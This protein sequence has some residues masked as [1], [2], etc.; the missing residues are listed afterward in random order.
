MGNEELSQEALKSDGSPF[1]QGLSN[2]FG[3]HTWGIAS[4]NKG[5]TREENVHRQAQGGA[6]DNSDHEKQ[7]AP[8][9]DQVDNKKNHKQTLCTLGFCESPSMKTLWHFLDHP[10][11]MSCHK[12]LDEKRFTK[13]NLLLPLI[14]HLKIYIYIG[15]I[16]YA[17]KLNQIPN[18]KAKTYRLFFVL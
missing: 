11:I 13:K 15:E 5:Q 12:S 14:R 8:N 18:P 2:E 4:I 16:Q 17:I 1:I 9:G 6:E 3:I 7:V 10:W